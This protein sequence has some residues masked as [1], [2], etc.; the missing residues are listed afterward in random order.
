MIFFCLKN[1]KIQT[2]VQPTI[3]GQ[4]ST[5]VNVSFSWAS[6]YPTTQHRAEPER[7]GK[8]A[9]ASTL[10][11][12]YGEHQP[13]PHHSH[14]RTHS[15]HSHLL[16][17]P[18]PHHHFTSHRARY[19]RG[20]C[21]IGASSRGA[22]HPYAQGLSGRPRCSASLLMQGYPNPTQI[23]V[24]PALSGKQGSPDPFL[25][26]GFSSKSVFDTIVL[27]ELAAAEHQR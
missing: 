23:Y 8:A 21:R 12:Q 15:H 9:G 24:S 1:I 25:T 20:P 27:V 16:P 14:S 22:V 4:R 18:S 13:H 5:T 11:R 26:G 19:R 3:V 6:S 17:W 7:R 10:P 2:N